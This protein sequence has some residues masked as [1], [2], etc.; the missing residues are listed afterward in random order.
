MTKKRILLHKK[1]LNLS[2]PKLLNLSQ[3]NF[4]WHGDLFAIAFGTSFKLLRLNWLNKKVYQRW[5]MVTL[6]SNNKLAIFVWKCKKGLFYLFL[7][8][9]SCT[10]IR[11]I[12][13]NDIWAEACIILDFKRYDFEWKMYLNAPRHLAQK[14]GVNSSDF[15]SEV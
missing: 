14:I 9:S 7:T 10:R 8:E 15:W 2:L 11:S 1:A 5:R 4:H 13:H 6:M 12:S 3:P